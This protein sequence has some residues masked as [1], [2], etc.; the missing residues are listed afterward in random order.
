METLEID[1]EIRIGHVLLKA[2]KVKLVERNLLRL[3]KWIEM[4]FIQRLIF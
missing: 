4:D 3:N 1:Y 2:L